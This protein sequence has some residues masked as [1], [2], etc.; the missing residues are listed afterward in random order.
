MTMTNPIIN[1]A[2]SQGHNVRPEYIYKF[3]IPIAIV[4]RTIPML[5]SQHPCSKVV[6]ARVRTVSRGLLKGKSDR[7]RVRWKTDT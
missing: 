1:V 5:I 2:D 6:S 7:R 4:H 3:T